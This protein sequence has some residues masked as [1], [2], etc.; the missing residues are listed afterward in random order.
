MENQIVKIISALFCLLL[1]VSVGASDNLNAA[2]AVF[3]RYKTLEVA[4]DSNIVDLYSDNAV[5]KNKRT[6]PTGQVR[7]MSLPAPKYKELIRGAMPLAKAK[8]DYSTYSE[9]EFIAEG[10]G[11]RMS[12]KRF[13]V[14]KKYT[15]NFSILFTP[16]ESGQWLIVEELSESQPF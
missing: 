10:N 8:G 13:S 12:A 14:L 16:N 6:Y 9:V 1:S 5:I 4:F 7:E 15:S 3:E 2:R 11:V